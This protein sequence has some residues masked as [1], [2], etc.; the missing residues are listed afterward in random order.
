MQVV[1]KPK[2]IRN[3]HCTQRSCC[4]SQPQE[5][6]QCRGAAFMWAKTFHGARALG[7]FQAGYRGRGVHLA[8]PLS[9]PFPCAV[10]SIFRVMCCRARLQRAAWVGGESWQ[11]RTLTHGHQPVVQKCPVP[12]FASREMFDFAL[13][14][15]QNSFVARPMLQYSRFENDILLVVHLNFCPSSNHKVP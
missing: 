5:C 9:P 2:L 10:C 8:I 6:T 1:Q 13:D 11:S 3:L 15:L 7:N 14:K 4:S 12:V